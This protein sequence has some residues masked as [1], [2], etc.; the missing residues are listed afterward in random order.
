MCF[1]DISCRG[2]GSGRGWLM[3]PRSS[4]G[5]LTVDEESE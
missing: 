5:E 2:E 3:E 4:L 1:P